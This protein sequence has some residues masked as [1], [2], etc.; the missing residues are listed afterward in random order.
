M[1]AAC[2]AAVL[3]CG[4]VG[5]AAAEERTE[6]F[7]KDPGWEGR[8]NRATTP[9]VRTVRQDFGYSRTA[10]A[11]GRPGEVGGFI[12]PAAEPAYYA[13][14]LRPKTFDDPLSASGTL[15]CR[16]RQF[17]LLIAF[18]NAG[19][20]NEWRTANTVALRL[21]GRGD[22]FYAYVEYCTGKWRA[23][24]DSPGGFAT[25]KN[26]TTGRVEPRGFKTGVAHHWSL[27]YDPAGNNGAGAVTVTLGGE[28]AVCHLAAGHKADG[29]VFDR[30][31]L[32]PVLKSADAGGEVWIADL[33]LDGR[34]EDLSRDPGWEGLNNRIVPAKVPTVTQDFGYS[35]TSF[36]GKEKGEVGGRVWRSTTPAY[37]GE[38]ITPKGL[39]DPLT[40]SGTFA[41]T[42]CSSGSG[43]FFGW[44]NAR[45]P[46]SGR[47][48]N[49][50][51]WYLD[52]EKTGARLYFAALT[53]TNRAHGKFVT[54]F[55]KGNKPTP[56][57]ADG[58]RHT[59]T[60]T[61]DPA[62]NDGAGRLRFVVAEP[63]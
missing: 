41:L 38:K 36:A 16:G 44:F 14:K 6:R 47:P 59:F 54:P 56:I 23:G 53:G 34:K 46:G 4:V 39:D 21:L 61:Y 10:N 15:L 5:W 18:F 30:F 8:N 22:V 49:S 25:V 19:T 17:H 24:G 26:P 45:Q 12:T 43:L 51:G 58:T 63:L 3:A 50:L 2:G 62:A 35:P 37:Y 27:K 32:L 60:L 20:V 7:D 55:E 28:T 1:R 11:G 57:K 9:E 40:M 31:G 29:A 42:A 33:T 48:T 52:G 13:R